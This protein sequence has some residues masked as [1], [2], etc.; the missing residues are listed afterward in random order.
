MVYVSRSKPSLNY[1]VLMHVYNEA[2]YLTKAVEAVLNQSLQPVHLVIIND[3]ST[4]ETQNIIERYTEHHHYL[5]HSEVK[6]AFIRRAEAF[7]YGINYIKEKLDLINGVLKVDGDIIIEKYYAEELLR[8]LNE[9]HTAAVS[10]TST[11]YKKTRNLNNGAVMY[12]LSTIPTARFMSGWDLDVELQLIRRGFNCI[13]DPTVSYTDLRPPNTFKP[14]KV[15]VIKNRLTR[16][17]S[18]IEGAVR[19]REK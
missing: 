7:N 11:E 3:E 1:G 4:D 6:P 17:I 8:H 13:V 16:K 9:P 18:E 5:S 15:N 14:S 12:R 10:G 2:E 19:K